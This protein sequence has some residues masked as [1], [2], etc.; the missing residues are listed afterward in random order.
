MSKASIQR[1]SANQPREGDLRGGHD[2]TESAKRRHLAFFM[3]HLHGGGVS[4]MRLILAGALADRGTL[5]ISGFTPLQS[6]S[7]RVAFTAAGL[8]YEQEAHLESW[9]LLV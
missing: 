4:K 6:P 9:A 7:L 1:L 2:K 8:A 3:H 5:L